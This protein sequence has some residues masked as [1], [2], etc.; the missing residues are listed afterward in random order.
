MTLL[1]FVLKVFGCILLLLLFLFAVLLVCPIWL[2]LKYE[3]G[4]PSV[5]AKVLGIKVNIYPPKPQK[6]KKKKKTKTQKGK[7]S[8]PTL[9]KYS[10]LQGTQTAKQAE[11]QQESGQL[12][13]AMPQEGQ[14]ENA[15]PEQICGKV[16]PVAQRVAQA[17]AISSP[18]GEN[19]HIADAM[20]AQAQG[21]NLQ[22]TGNA[23]AGNA[24]QNAPAAENKDTRVVYRAPVKQEADEAE[25]IAEKPQP[26]E[27]A[28]TGADLTKCSEGKKT[29]K[30][31]ESNGGTTEE[32]GTESQGETTKEKDALAVF[33][34]E[35]V[36]DIIVLAGG[37]I[38]R[39]LAALKLEEVEASFAVGG[40][41]PAKV[42]LNYGRTNAALAAAFAT[43]AN[44]VQVKVKNVTVHPYFGPGSIPEKRPGIKAACRIGT[45]LASML[46]VGLYVLL[47]LKK[48]GFFKTLKMKLKK[49]ST[50]NK[51]EENKHKKEEP[52]LKKSGENHNTEVKI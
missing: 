3:E 4:V 32:A 34:F 29:E 13:V 14:H 52:V 50:A 46:A 43:L 31:A 37:T 35:N 38:K 49:E 39:F 11:P 10:E 9:P 12:P 33:L 6:S 25:N 15:P 5:K 48:L 36:Y 44:I 24:G 21:E 42:A 20:L 41:D 26:E 1:F 40:G 22:G 8:P 47:K 7:T 23:P 45:S 18:P 27:S 30:D 51:A 17:P 16:L 28:A 19:V 2:Y